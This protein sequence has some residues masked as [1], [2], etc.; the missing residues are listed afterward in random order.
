MPEPS[1]LRRQR[2]TR[3]SAVALLLAA[4][5]F[6]IIDQVLKLCLE[7]GS[8]SL[9]VTEPDAQ[10]ATLC[11][12][13]QSSGKNAAC[14]TVFMDAFI[15]WVQDNP[16]AGSVALAAVYAVGAVCFV[17]GS[18]LTLGAG[19]A[20]GAALGPGWGVVVGT[21]AVWVGAAVGGLCAFMLGRL[22][23]HKLV[24]RLLQRWK[25]T[26]ALDAALREEGLKLMVLLRLS[27][28]IPFNALNYILAGTSVPAS[29]YVLALPAMLPGTVAYVYLGA[30][31]AEAAR[32]ASGGDGGEAALRIGLLVAGL[33]L[34]FAAVIA[35]SVYAKRQL[36]RR[37]ASPGGGEE[38]EEED[39]E[40]GRPMREGGGG[41]ASK[42]SRVEGELT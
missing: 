32:S 8:G 29:K 21:L 26:A 27:P 16:A 7:D 36:G 28:L 2:A 20:F 33:V 24:N 15:G 10:N 41:S 39:G 11:S 37:L 22:A 25:I 1:I 3:L 35:L 9:N 23:L 30:S 14:T 38:E 4:I 19:A 5:V 40:A 17:P 42:R 18:V 6:V 12:D 31:V 34:T 13:C